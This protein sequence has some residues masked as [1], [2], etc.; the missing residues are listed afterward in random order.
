MKP[1]RL[2]PAMCVA[3]ALTLAACGEDT[4]ESGSV[5]DG[6]KEDAKAAGLTL[7]GV[8]CPSPV[9]KKGESFTCTVTVKGED[10]DFEV[11]QTDDKGGLEYS[12]ALTALLSGGGGGDEASV[13]SVIDA[14]NA[15][16]T[17]LCDYTT[18]A[19]KQEIVDQ[20]GQQSCEDAV[21][22]EKNDPIQDYKVTVDGDTAT[23]NGTDSNGPVVVTLT[24]AHD[25]TWEISA[26]G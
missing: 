9:A 2:V 8:D 6:I 17:A 23:V 7:D 24:R 16:F 5:E 19:Y 1:S 3:A 21:A 20:T 26:I 14:V 15:D 13:S 4:I 10:S 12:A 25:G 22:S 18:D 11:N